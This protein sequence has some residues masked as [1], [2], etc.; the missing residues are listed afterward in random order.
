V[1]RAVVPDGCRQPGVGDEYGNLVEG[2]D[3]S[4][5]CLA[6]LRALGDQDGPCCRALCGLLRCGVSEVVGHDAV[7]GVD[8]ATRHDGGIES[9]VGESALQQWATD[10]ALDG[11]DL[12]A[13]DDD[14]RSAGES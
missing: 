1:L 4:G 2:A 6:E 14:T 10:G 11:V 3:P 5:G 9:E 8:P 7:G 13:P 12:A